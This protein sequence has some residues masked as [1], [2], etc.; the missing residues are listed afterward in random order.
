MQIIDTSCSNGFIQKLIEGKR[1]YIYLFGER[2]VSLKFALLKTRILA[3]HNFPLFLFQ[4]H[5]QINH[6]FNRFNSIV[7]TIEDGYGFS[8][9]AGQKNCF[10]VLSFVGEVEAAFQRLKRFATIWWGT[11][12]SLISDRLLESFQV[13]DSGKLI[14]VEHSMCIQ[15]YGNFNSSIAQCSIQN[16]G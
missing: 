6:T 12:F 2:G 15:N 4:N 8:G 13:I 14:S 10:R 7:L 3:V 11:C 16:M 5:E 9:R 1:F